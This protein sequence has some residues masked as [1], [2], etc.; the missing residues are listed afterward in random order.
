MT[1]ILKKFFRDLKFN[2]AQISTI[3]IIIA[4]AITFF[5]GLISTTNSLS[6]TINNY[7]QTTNLSDIYAYSN[8]LPVNFSKDILKTKDVKETEERIQTTAD[9]KNKDIV[10]NS[11]TDVINKTDFISGTSP[12]ENQIAIDH[13]FM[14]KNKLK[15]GDTIHLTING[16]D[17]SL[18]ISGKIQ[19][20]EYLYQIKDPAQPVPNHHSYGY[21]VMDKNYLTNSFSLVNNQLLVTTGH[22]NNS[23]ITN[24]LKKKYQNV[25]FLTKDKQISYQVFK[26]KLKAIED[27]AFILPIIFCLLASIMTFISMVRYVE[28]QRQNIAIM[29]AFGH[30]NRIV[31]SSLLILPSITVLIG[32]LLGGMIGFLLLPNKLISTLTILFDLPKIV[33]ADNLS[34]LVLFILL[35]LLLEYLATILTG[36]KII[37]EKPAHSMRQQVSKV[38]NHSLLEKIPFIWQR[39]NFE[40][41]LVWH[42]ISLAKFRFLLSSI[43]IIFSTCLIIS[44]LGLKLAISDIIKSE[45]STTR[46]YDIS[47]KLATPTLNSSKNQYDISSLKS[48]DYETSLPVQIDSK[49]SNINVINDEQ[50]SIH[51]QN[52]KGKDIQFKNLDGI[53]ISKKLMQEL[54]LKNGQNIK[55]TLTNLDGRTQILSVKI[56]ESY[57]SYTSQGIYT[58]YSYLHKKGVEVPV[59]TLLIHSNNITNSQKNLSTN[60]EF[61]SYTIKNKQKIDYTNASKS[62]NE[63]IVMMTTASALLLFTIIYNISSINIFERKRDIAIE[64]VLGLKDSEINSLIFK[65]NF[66]LVLFSSLIGIVLSP[67]FYSLICNSLSPE[68]MAFPEKLN[69]FSIPMSICLIFI[70]LYLTHLFLKPKIKKVDMLESLKSIE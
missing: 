6:T 22:S 38:G 48:Y 2:I 68:N 8:E 25:L 62:I 1:F 66:I 15:V 20:S 64:K 67:S 63:I 46:T 26:T 49:L 39:L 5:T 70:F 52:E 54:H 24:Q 30:P 18:T 65:E 51:L 3:S 19:S 32:S 47:A 44:S 45:F 27:M 58:T 40:N 59:S 16:I 56:I 21:A 61:T 53:F 12:K 33:K 23:S 9:W 11:Q 57:I 31:Y 10:I 28:N 36:Q 55:L 34:G 14:E 17:K 43:G 35:V 29:K 69:L 4:I 60:K 41:K 50:D 42:N 13:L 37:K 7:Y